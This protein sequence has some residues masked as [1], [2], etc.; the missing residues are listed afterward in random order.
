MI[1]AAVLA[2]GASRRLG[3]PK[4]LAIVGGEPLV[5]IAAQ[6]A[7]RSR[8]AETAVILGA[9]AGAIAPLL[10]GHGVTLL[11]NDQWEEGMASS[12]RRAAT[13]ARTRGAA[14]LVV[15]V[16]DQPLLTAQH[17]DA[18]ITLHEAHGGAIVA[19]RYAGMLGVPA[20]F[21][22]TA[23]P[24]LEALTGDRGARDLLRAPDTIALD[25]PDG[26]LDVDDELTLRSAQ[27]RRP[28]HP[29]TAP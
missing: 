11:A 5:L 23:L 19:S 28:G 7:T 12:L 8:C 18:L 15:C 13:W 10:V 24:Q 1:A 3:R 27:Y 16:C 21:G 22:P 6:A 2:A 14:S 26:A 17:V 4:Q 20:I 29:G 25:W 9:S